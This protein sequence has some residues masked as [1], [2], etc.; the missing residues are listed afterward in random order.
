MYV[1]KMLNDLADR[2]Q[3]RLDYIKPVPVKRNTEKARKARKEKVREWF[4]ENMRD[5]LWSTTTISAKRG[6]NNS[7]CLPL[8]YDLEEEGFLERVG[9]GVRTGRG[10]CPIIW[11]L[12]NPPIK[13]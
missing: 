13:E 7:S 5:Q 1:P 9:E 2:A 12:T 10:K 3:Y 8:L 11:K 4:R 6:Q